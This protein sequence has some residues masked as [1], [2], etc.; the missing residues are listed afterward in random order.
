MDPIGFGLENYDAAGAW[1]DRDGKF[2]IDSS[3]KLPG[4]ASFSGSK[5]L[6]QV[7][8]SQSALFTRN[9]TERM[10]TYALGR[11][12]ESDDRS[13]VDQ[14][15]QRVAATGNRFSTLVT[16]IV[17][18]RAFQMRKEVGGNVASR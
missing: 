6:K 16:E 7:L 3:G 8:K 11:G 18:S 13:A 9:L 1:R 4:G 2:P 10:L 5:D 15:T 14:I 12:I 17:N